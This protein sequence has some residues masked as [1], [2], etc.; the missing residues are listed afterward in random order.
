MSVNGEK[1][2][3]IQDDILSNQLSIVTGAAGTGKSELLKQL[4]LK[5]E[6]KYKSSLKQTSVPNNVQI[7]IFI[8]LKECING[9][10]E[11]LLRDRLNDF[12]IN[13]ANFL[14][15]YFYFTLSLHLF[16]KRVS[17]IRPAEPA[18]DC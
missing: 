4:Y 6:V 14:S 3:S 1:F 12:C 8:R 11:S 7:P 5:A 9:N 13:I 2:F 17:I 10:L 15:A 16:H 18:S